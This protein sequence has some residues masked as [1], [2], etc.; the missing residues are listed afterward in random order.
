[1]CFS[2]SKM[3]FSQNMQFSLW[4][5]RLIIFAPTYLFTVSSELNK[6]ENNT[7]SSATPI[8]KKL[9]LTE[10]LFSSLFWRIP[11]YINPLTLKIAFISH[12]FSQFIYVLQFK[13]KKWRIGVWKVP[14]E[15]NFLCHPPFFNTKNSKIDMNFYLGL[16]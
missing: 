13:H 3:T 6:V 12:V 4:N 15:C 11:I 5:Q 9:A 16:T 8:E 2:L 1:M 10:K 7:S 14:K